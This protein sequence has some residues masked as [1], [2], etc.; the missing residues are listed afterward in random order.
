MTPPV[1]VITGASSG[2]GEGMARRPH[3]LAYGETIE[4]GDTTVDGEV[5]DGI[6]VVD[7]L[8]ELLDLLGAPSAPQAGADA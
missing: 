7:F 5:R 6:N 1:A 4:L 3:A 2:L 8:A